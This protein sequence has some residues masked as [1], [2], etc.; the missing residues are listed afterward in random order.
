MG[1]TY[2]ARIIHSGRVVEAGGKT[3]RADTLNRDPTLR[4][5]SL[6]GTVNLPSNTV[7]RS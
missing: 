6:N 3:F 5:R 2:E 7:R 1:E 4:S